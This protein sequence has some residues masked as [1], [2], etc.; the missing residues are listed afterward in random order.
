MTSDATADAMNEASS[1]IVRASGAIAEIGLDAG[2]LNLVTRGMLRALNRAFDEI[3]RRTDIRCMILHGRDGRAF[4]ASRTW[5][6]ARG[7][8]RIGHAWI[9]DSQ[10]AASD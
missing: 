3:A 10:E 9:P 5:N 8:H 6:S 2:P 1:V 4:C 7:R